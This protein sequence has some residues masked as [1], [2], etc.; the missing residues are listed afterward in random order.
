MLLSICQSSTSSPLRSALPQRSNNQPG[1]FVKAHLYFA[2]RYLC[3]GEEGGGGGGG[4]VRMLMAEL[5]TV[6]LTP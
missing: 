4:A 5:S 3:Q 2:G 6:K 1:S